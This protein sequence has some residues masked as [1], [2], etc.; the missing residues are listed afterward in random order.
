MMSDLRN[1]NM[2]QELYFTL[3]QHNY[4]YAATPAHLPEYKASPGITV[5]LFGVTSQGWAATAGHAALEAGKMCSVYIGTAVGTPTFVTSAG[6]VT[7]TG[8]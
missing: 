7:C 6:V 1:L 4:A 2:Q 8:D 3:P 5:S